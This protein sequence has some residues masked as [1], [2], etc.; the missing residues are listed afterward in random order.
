[1]KLPPKLPLQCRIRPRIA[2][3]LLLVV[4]LLFLAFEAFVNDFQSRY[5]T[6]QSPASTASTTT[7]GLNLP[8]FLTTNRHL[9]DT[10][11]MEHVKGMMR[12]AWTGYVQYA[13]GSDDLQPVSRTGYNW[14]NSQNLLNTPV[15]SLDTLYIMGMMDEYKSA[16][17]LVLTKLDFANVT[18]YV[19]LFETNIRVLGG[20]LAAYDLEGDV[21]VLR[22][23]VELADRMVPAFETATGIPWN[24]INLATGETKPDDSGT[25]ILSELGS[26]QLEF[27]YLSDVTGN[28]IYA[29][30]A[31][32]VYEQMQTIA[33]DIP[34]LFPDAFRVDRLSVHGKKVAIGGRCDSY[35]EYLL[36]MWL[37]TGEDKYYEYYY[38]AAKSIADNML[39]RSPKGHVYIPAGFIQR[40]DTGF[41][42]QSETMFEHL[43]CFAGGMFATGALAS[44]RGDWT[45]HLDIGR[46]ITDACWG[47]YNQSSTGIGSENCHGE[48]LQLF[49]TRYILRPEAIESLFYMWRFTH[50][51]VYRE[52]AWVIVQNLDKYCKNEVGYHGLENANAQL[53]PQLQWKGGATVGPGKIDRQE[54]FFLA[55]SLKYL[56]LIFADDDTIPLEQYVFNTEAH[57][58]SVRGHGRRKN[59][60]KFVELP[61]KYKMAPGTLWTETE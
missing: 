5:E 14:Y 22:K 29:E 30:K 16:K 57:P 1:M 59:K 9:K 28:P 6:V 38:T 49:N 35:Y 48:S 20:L 7:G 10:E 12:H 42:I 21:K 23:C 11:K 47:M 3:L 55:E 53:D 13:W 36:K 15:D 43:T 46:G 37:S 60:A 40:S 2:S 19:S 45:K 18:E 34:G 51:P 50:D 25:A 41:K 24:L 58:L 32:F 39:V 54:S 4:F 33:V 44:R 17:R 26:L 8:P 61:P 56:Y 52:R 31:L 27:Q